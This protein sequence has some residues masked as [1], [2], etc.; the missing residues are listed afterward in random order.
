MRALAHGTWNFLRSPV[1]VTALLWGACLYGGFF[2]WGQWPRADQVVGVPSALPG[3]EPGQAADVQRILGAPSA[4]TAA[5]PTLALPQLL[6]VLSGAPGQSQALLALPGQPAKPYGWG[7]RLPT[8]WR[9]Q[10]IEPR[11]VQLQAP[12]GSAHWLSLPERAPAKP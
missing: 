7:Q 10:A 1:W 5:E 8:G 11:R 12:D 9:V 6:G 4:P 2:W 3:F